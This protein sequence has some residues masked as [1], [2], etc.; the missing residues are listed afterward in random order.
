[1]SRN[2]IVKT[3]E[4]LERDRLAEIERHKWLESERLGS[5]IGL[6]TA[7]ND[8]MDKHFPGWVQHQRET[9]LQQLNF[10]S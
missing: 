4:N 10:A 2:R 3:L 7:E 5:D 1:M 6:P 9:V 8:W